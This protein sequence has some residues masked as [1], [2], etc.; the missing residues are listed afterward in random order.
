MADDDRYGQPVGLE[1]I[2]RKM[3]LEVAKEQLRLGKIDEPRFKEIEE[4]HTCLLYT[5]DAGDE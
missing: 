1:T 4:H 2:L 5:S 3:A